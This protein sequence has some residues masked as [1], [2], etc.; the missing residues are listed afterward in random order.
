MHPRPGVSISLS[1]LIPLQGE[2]VLYRTNTY[3]H[4]PGQAGRQ[5]GGGNSDPRA[6]DKS[7]K[8]KC[9]LA[10]HPWAL[11]QQAKG[12]MQ[13][14]YVV[15]VGGGWLPTRL[16]SLLV[17]VAAHGKLRG[18]AVSR[19]NEWLGWAC[20]NELGLGGGEGRG[21]RDGL[22]EKRTGSWEA[23]EGENGG[24]PTEKTHAL[25]VRVCG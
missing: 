2:H 4:L 14:P 24:T 16:L 8:Q 12:P 19:S 13:L 7:T 6:S 5:A 22:D 3:P 23:V 1:L 20:S 17:V 11:F 15:C 18:Q 21:G 10:S 25:C 9:T